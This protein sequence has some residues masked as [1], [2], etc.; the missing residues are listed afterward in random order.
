MDSFLATDWLK[1]GH[2][3]LAVAGAVQLV[4]L[5][6]AGIFMLVPGAEPERT[7]LRI[8]GFLSLFSRKK[9]DQKKQEQVVTEAATI[10]TW[11]AIK[12]IISIVPKVIGLI[13]NLAKQ[14]KEKEF[15]DWINDLDETT[16]AL[17]MAESTADRVAAAKRLRDLARRM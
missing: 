12:I 1:V 13:E 5:G 2:D 6:V 4:L 11:E 15:N 17:E 10:G 7:L 16:R 3:I 9:Q 14:M 8:A